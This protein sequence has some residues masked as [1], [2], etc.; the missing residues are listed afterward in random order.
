M[1]EINSKVNKNSKKFEQLLGEN[2]ELKK[3]NSELRE[4]VS[5]IKTAQL[6]N[7]IIISGIPKQPFETYEKTKQR[8]YDTFA[9]AIEASDPITLAALLDK[10]KKVDI[11]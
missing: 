2:I 5:K 10:A 3:E 4:R 11:V 9:S 1:N 7:D 8:I 6:S